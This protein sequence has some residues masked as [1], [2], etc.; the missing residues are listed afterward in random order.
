VGRMD[1]GEVVLEVVVVRDGLWCEFSGEVGDIGGRGSG[2]VLIGI[3][4]WC[5]G[6]LGRG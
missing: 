6:G 4:L 5:Y 3:V 2:D 1:G